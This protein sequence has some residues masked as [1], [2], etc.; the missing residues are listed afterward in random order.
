MTV[1][2]EFGFPLPPNGSLIAAFPQ[3]VRQQSQQLE[4]RLPGAAEAASLR[5]LTA[6][7][8]VTGAEDGVLAGL[9]AALVD[10]AGNVI[11]EVR[12]DGS[13]SIPG[14]E[15]SA[16]GG[17]PDPGPDPGPDPVESSA[18]ILLPSPDLAP[19]DMTTWSWWGSSTMQGVAS[20]YKAMATAHGAA[21][22]Y[23]G[24]YGAEVA[25]H[26]A[27]RLGSRPALPAEPF[28]I[29]A[30]GSVPVEIENMP[31]HWGTVDYTVTIAGVPGRLHKSGGNPATNPDPGYYFTRTTAGD[32]VD[33]LAFMP[34][35][36]TAA[37]WAR[38]GLLI[39]NFGKNN[40][41]SSTGG[42]Q[43]V[44]ALIDMTVT[45][46]NYAAHTAKRVLVLGH[47]QDSNK[48]P[49]QAQWNLVAEYNKRAKDVF[50]D[51]FLDLDAMVK[52]PDVWT[53]TG[54]TPTAT[55][56][57]QQARGVKPDSISLDSQ[58]LNAAGYDVLTAYTE[59]KMTALGWI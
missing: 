57:D 13:V 11:M 34:F 55:D 56:L 41:S 22:T 5:A 29:P 47:W 43:D 48:L 32:P 21:R 37:P 23:G 59:N 27:A 45:A 36:P 58:H 19:A 4:A 50:G 2:P 17:A 25:E 3:V 12:T 33:V 14:L 7:R 16:G 15:Q 49:G 52:S 1:T 8:V 51:R 6:A 28:T 24:G 40:L 38:D 10:D 35:T 53:I 54:L 18:S 20:D 42:T 44:R 46:Y 9:H 26:T 30:S 31:I 39:L